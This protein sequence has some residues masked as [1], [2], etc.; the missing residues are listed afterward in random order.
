[1]LE[2]QKKYYMKHREKVLDKSKN[3]NKE[4]YQRNKEHLRNYYLNNREMFLEYQKQYYKNNREKVLNRNK[5][6][7]R[8]WRQRNREYIRGYNMERY[9][10]YKRNKQSEPMVQTLSIRFD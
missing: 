10:G 6:Y 8:E 5:E 9:Y 7:Q 2:Y 1:M 4:W 3:Y